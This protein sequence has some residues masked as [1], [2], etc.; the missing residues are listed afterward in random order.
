MA[1]SF[2]TI[3]GEL[4]DCGHEKADHKNA[5]GGYAPGHGSCNKCSCDKFTWASFIFEGEE[6]ETHNQEGGSMD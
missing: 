4:C 5:L 2:D 1:E 3:I 6:A